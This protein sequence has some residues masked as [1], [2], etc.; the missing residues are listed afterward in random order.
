MPETFTFCVGAPAGLRIGR[1]G[2]END[3]AVL[4]A[5]RVGLD[6]ALGVDDRVHH[7]ACRR[8]GE[9]N[10]AAIGLERSLVLDQRIERLAGLNVPDGAGD[11]VADIQCQKLVAIE[12]EG[13]AVGSGQTDLA[14]T[15]A[16]GAGVAHARRH[17]GGEAAGG[18]RDVAGIDDRGIGL[19]RLAEDVAA[20]HEVV[21]LDVVRGRHQPA[22]I[23]HRMRSEQDAIRVDEEDV[24]V[25]LE[26][27]VDLRGS[28]AA[29][30]PVER[31]RTGARL[32]EPGCLA[33][34]D[35]EALP[36]DDG[37]V[38]RL[39]DGEVR[40]AFAGDMRLTCRNR[41]PDRIGMGRRRK[42]QR[43]QCAGGKQKSLGRSPHRM[44]L[45]SA[46]WRSGNTASRRPCAPSEA[47]KQ[48]CPR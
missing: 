16:D 1:R 29:G 2:A 22:D 19:A 20:G 18:R 5:D 47:W 41:C 31:D 30:D 39:V 44:A 45:S 21:V 36:V 48:R 17:Q 15:G 42:T 38:G 33:S 12:V 3:L 10:Y 14:E 46:R 26:G 34:A 6:D 27:A 11:L 23:D 7:L 25:G 8:R 35:I 9:L 4:H 32:D 28:E 24:A 13:E 37:L 43:H 40:R